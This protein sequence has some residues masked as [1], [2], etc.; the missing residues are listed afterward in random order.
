MTTLENTYSSFHSIK[1]FISLFKSWVE[2]CLDMFPLSV[3]SKAIR[4]STSLYENGEKSTSKSTWDS[5]QNVYAY[6]YLLSN[7]YFNF[8]P[9]INDN[10]SEPKM[11]N[12][13]LSDINIIAEYLKLQLNP[14]Q[15]EFELHKFTYMQ[16]F[17]QYRYW[18][19]FWR[20]ATIWKNSQMNFIT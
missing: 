16:I 8:S 11:E 20:F 2:T 3:K 1:L 18:K 10:S 12:W 19:I 7:K 9:I 6:F 5:R 17:F 15:H 14:E 13:E 4:V